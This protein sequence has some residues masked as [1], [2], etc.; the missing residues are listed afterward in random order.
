MIE[1]SQK[2]PRSFNWLNVAQFGGALNDNI[3]KLLVIFFLIAL[4]GEAAASVTASVVG[5][6]FVIPFLLFTQIGRAHV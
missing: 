4:K 3:F 5:A 6:L 1:V 2:M